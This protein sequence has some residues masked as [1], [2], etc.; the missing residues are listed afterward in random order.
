VRF[1][2]LE[3]GKNLLAVYKP[4]LAYIVASLGF[5]ARDHG[6]S[7]SV[8]GGGVFGYRHISLSKCNLFTK[9]NIKLASITSVES[10]HP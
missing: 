8:I 9:I 3:K 2:F 4:I 6:I 10:Y 1:G 5:I 7:I